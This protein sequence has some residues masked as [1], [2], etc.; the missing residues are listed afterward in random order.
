MTRR[1]SWW[2][3]ERVAKAFDRVGLDVVDEPERPRSD[4]AV[5]YRCRECGHEGRKTPYRAER[6]SGCAKCV[7]R[8]DQTHGTINTYKTLGCRCGECRAAN[9]D[10]QRDLR[11]RKA[12]VDGEVRGRGVGMD[13]LICGRPLADHSVLAPCLLTP[14]GSTWRIR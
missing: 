7:R 12:S 11:R 6:G 13:C 3:A 4:R 5:G 10:Y 14:A 8:P 1:Y 9:A 2:N